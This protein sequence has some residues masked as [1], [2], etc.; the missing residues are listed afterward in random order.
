MNRQSKLSE[1]YDTIMALKGAEDFKKKIRRQQSFLV[2]KE[3]CDQD[4]GISF[5][6]E[7]WIVR[8]GGGVTTLLGAYAQY[9]H[10]ARAMEFC[11]LDKFLEFNLDY[12][13]PNATFSELARLD[14]SISV[15]TGHNRYYKGIICININSWAHYT[16]DEH[17][18]KFIN[19]IA[20]NKD[21]WLTIFIV[22][23]PR[24]DAVESIETA[25]ARRISF[26]THDIRFPESD[27][28]LEL[29]EGWLVSNS[30]RLTKGAKIMLHETIGE[31][32]KGKH[33]HGFRTIR[34]LTESIIYTVLTYHMENRHRITAQMLSQYSKDSDYVKM[35]KA[36][37][38]TRKPIGF[39]V[40]GGGF[41]HEL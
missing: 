11:G 39:S 26:E 3:A 41:Q 24:G 23:A 8:R 15:K 20:F 22:Y 14:R 10:A 27:E 4:M 31:L 34:Q 25:L 36:Q 35:S 21:K 33:F 16:E 17:F 38:N 12:V 7:L 6:S 30:I 13:A 1:S 5:P 2:N 32:A 18:T 29:V 19:Y 28:M 40:D 37:I 9:L